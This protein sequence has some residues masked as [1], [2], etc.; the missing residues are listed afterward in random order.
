ML[1]SATLSS[2]QLADQLSSTDQSPKYYRYYP[3]L[4]ASYFSEIERSNVEKLCN[5]GYLYYQFI[6]LIDRIIDDKDL[7]KIPTSIIL[8]EEAIKILA[9]LFSE[10][11]DFWKLWNARRQEYFKS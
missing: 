4:F 8:Q 5:A 10:E 2:S 1:E 11:S 3:R 7:S 9:T 6:L